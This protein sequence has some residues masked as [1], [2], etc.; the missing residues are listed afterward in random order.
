[1]G[2]GSRYE[3]FT[4]FNNNS[5]MTTLQRREREKDTKITPSRGVGGGWGDK[6]GREDIS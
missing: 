5:F 1:M 2:G 4:S 6:D 3:W